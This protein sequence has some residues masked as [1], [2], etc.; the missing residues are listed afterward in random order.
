[1]TGVTRMGILNKHYHGSNDP[2]QLAYDLGIDP[3]KMHIVKYIT[4]FRRKGGYRDLLAAKFS[5]QRLKEVYGDESWSTADL[6][7]VR[8]YIKEDTLILDRFAKDNSL[9]WLQKATLKQFLITTRYS[10]KYMEELD[11]V[12]PLI[13]RLIAHEYPHEHQRVLIV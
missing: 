10:D 3:I 1:M 6:P 8:K 11:N 7:Y 12:L 13:D 4:R 2:Y 9:S 5:I